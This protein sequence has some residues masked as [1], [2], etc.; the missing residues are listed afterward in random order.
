[1]GASPDPA[2]GVFDTLLVR[3]GRGVDLERH[4]DR[5]TRSVRE[6]YGVPVDAEALAERVLADARGID[7]ARVRTSYEPETGSWTIVAEPV[8]VPGPDPRTLVVRRV[9]TGL[10]AHK[11]ADRRLVEVPAD[12]GDVLLAD[13]AGDVL[14][15]GSASVFAVLG[16]VV[17]TP[18]LDGRILP[19]TVRARVLDRLRTEGTAMAER[20][21]GLLELGSASEVFAT[22]SIR[23]VQP[24]SACRDV[25]AWPTGPVTLRLREIVA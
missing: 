12:A 20:P 23:G 18:P 6:L 13:E 4:L 21:V 1:V 17:V 15:C 2:Y 19:G 14:E 11:W 5:L 22:S 3:D 24:V 25:G 16:G 9:A 7:P 10:G 8:Q